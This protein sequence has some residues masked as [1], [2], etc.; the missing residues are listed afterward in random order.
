MEF[1]LPREEA[2]ASAGVQGA[3]V[4]GCG[5]EADYGVFVFVES[6]A[7]FV[8]VLPRRDCARHRM[9]PILHMMETAMMR[10]ENTWFVAVFHSTPM[11]D[12]G[13]EEFQHP[14]RVC[15]CKGAIVLPCI[16]SCCC[17]RRKPPAVRRSRLRAAEPL[18]TCPPKSPWY[19]PVVAARRACQ[20]RRGAWLRACATRRG[21]VP[22]VLTR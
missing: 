13:P 18:G 7:L 8:V 10:L 15:V 19:R 17:W 20:W 16:L 2:W 12:P 3:R 6:E 9:I 21:P 4:G 11:H 1:C 5:C 22:G 14:A